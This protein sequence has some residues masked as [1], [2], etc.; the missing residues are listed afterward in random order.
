MTALNFCRYTLSTIFVF[1]LN[2]WIAGMG[3]GNVFNIMGAIA[4][5]TL[6]FAGFFIWRGKHLRVKTAKVYS[7][8]AARQYEARPL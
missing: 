8:Y 7:Y 4:L 2:P 3:V 1:A 6:S 5:T